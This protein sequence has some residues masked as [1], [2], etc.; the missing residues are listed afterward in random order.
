MP[1]YK[2]KAIS[3]S[4]E[5]HAG[6]TFAQTRED[7]AE[8]LIARGLFVTRI[9]RLWFSGSYRRPRIEE[10]LFFI[11]EFTV[12]LRSGL[13][14][15]EA[16]QITARGRKTRFGEVLEQVRQDVL[17]GKRISDAFARFSDVFEPLFLKMLDAGE[18][19]GEL[20][21]SLQHYESL[22]VRK[23][24]LWRKVRQ[25]LL[26]PAFILL[27]VVAILVI[28]FQFSLPRFIELYSGM[29][30]ELPEA[31]RFL[32]AVSDNF[33]V[34]AAAFM[35]GGVLLWQGGRYV[36][37]NNRLVT[38][39]DKAMLKLPFAGEVQRSYL[40]A[41]FGRT[42]SSLLANGTPVV[43]ALSH[44]AASLPNRHYSS[45]L[46]AISDDVAK[47]VSLTAA[48]RKEELFPSA[49]EKIIEAGER[50]G[51]LDA[52]LIEI[53]GFYE[54]DIDY[55]LNMAVA[56]VEPLMILLTGII[57]GGVVVVMYL[58]IFS[59]ASTIS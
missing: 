14:L 9:S 33:S 25:A 1:K 34:I 47:G 26:Y 29:D 43:E 40:I 10:L 56:L 28:I 8:E 16:I 50:S 17:Q 32:I 22:L 5:V 11:K 13:P 31:T 44:T 15:P 41:M 57:V 53:A 52:Q 54:N 46:K 42:L 23:L 19:S 12:L 55:R 27:I 2:Y 48:I 30:A 39:L 38:L 3:E 6:V 37:K 59:L 7:L 45:K 49:A 35:L 4:G 21:S 20:A 36:R 18:R 51:S 58:P 24:A